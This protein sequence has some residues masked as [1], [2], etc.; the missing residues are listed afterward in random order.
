MLQHHLIYNKFI[1]F[2]F[3]KFHKTAANWPNIDPPGTVTM[4]VPIS[5][6]AFKIEP[7]LQNT[8]ENRAK[9]TNPNNFILIEITS[10][11]LHETL[12]THNFNYCASSDYFRAFI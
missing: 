6:T 8:T 11:T 1:R 7:G 2:F 5:A 3:I 9:N 12:L 10:T 4:P